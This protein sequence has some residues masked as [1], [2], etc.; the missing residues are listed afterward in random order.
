M[1][2]NTLNPVIFE[3]GPLEVRWYG[4]AYLLGALFAY[5]A[6]I[7]AQKKGKIALSKNEIS[8]LISWLVLG[9]LIGSRL[10]YVLFYN[11]LYF[12]EQPWKIIAVWEGGMSFH[13]G[14][15][16][17]V[18]A[19][20]LFCKRK[21]MPLIH[22]ADI[23]SA[24]LMAALALGRVANFI[25]GELWGRPSN[26][27]WCVVFPAADDI[28]RH[29]Y[30]LYDGMKRFILAVWLYYLGR[31]EYP[32]GFV[33]WNLVFFEGLGR[34]VLDFWKEVGP[35]VQEP[36]VLFLTPGQWMSL[37]MVAVSGWFLFKHL[38]RFKK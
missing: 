13:G 37:A 5:W 16:G 35:H 4:V 27:A 33:F 6:L 29:P 7:S 1:W 12:V 24:P 32:T 2:V 14:F 25:N 8:D 31:G 28:C 30:Q 38:T 34:F 3:L 19:A 11:P 22:L 9:V 10:F 26:A 36:L 18:V 15:V 17:I 21:S 20:Y 23:L